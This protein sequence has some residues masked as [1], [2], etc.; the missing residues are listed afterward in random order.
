[1]KDIQ[2]SF[3]SEYLLEKATSFLF[4]PQRT[5]SPVVRKMWDNVR[6]QLVEWR[7]TFG[8][9]YDPMNGIVKI[10]NSPTSL[11]EFYCREM[12]T[13]I[14]EI[15]DRTLK[16][17]HLTLT[18]ISDSEF[19]LLREAANSYILGLPLAAVALARAAVEEA[20]RK[21]L[22]PTFGED[23]IAQANLTKLINIYS[24]KILS[25]EGQKLANG[26]R[27]AANK[28]LHEQGAS[29]ADGLGAIG[30]G[31]KSHSRTESQQQTTERIKRFVASRRGIT[32]NRG[33]SGVFSP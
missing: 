6:R 28:V 29:A 2:H 17:S 10:L 15:V 30:V 21:G 8:A 1:M 33:L 13:G 7:K 12:L 4:Y 9:P 23:L 3:L 11:N 18:G 31:E 25:K 14:P 5:R 20:L 24:S 26:V 19:R 16:L 32:P 22:Q 27:L